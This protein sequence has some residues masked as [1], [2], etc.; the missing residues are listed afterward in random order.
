MNV[1]GGVAT[2]SRD[3]RRIEDLLHDADRAMYRAKAQGG[4]DFALADGNAS[5]RPARRDT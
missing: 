1:N 4:G 2:D 3:I 5:P